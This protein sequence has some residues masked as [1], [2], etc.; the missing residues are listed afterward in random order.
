MSSP[1]VAIIGAGHM[2]GA[3]LKGL[4]QSGWDK[5]KLRASCH[6]AQHAAEIYKTFQINI[7]Q[8]NQTAI[9][10]A[11]IILLCVKPQIMAAVVAEISETLKSR[12]CIVISIAAGITESQLRAWLTPNYPIIRAMPNLP[13][14]IGMSATAL[15]AN[16]FCSAGQRQ[17]AETIFKAIGSIAWVEKED[18]FFAITAL[19]G[20][21]PAYF[22]SLMDA[23]EKAARTYGL[24]EQLIKN[25]TLQTALGSAAMAQESL[26]SSEALCQKV[27]SPGGGTEQALNM[28]N[29]LQFNEIILKA[30]A[31]AEQRYR[32]LAEN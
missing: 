6:S 16:R 12:P 11:E 19:Y 4:I 10:E 22:F 21:G 23:L 14:A 15:Y 8:C 28:L 5:S 32:K 17:I 3:I 25:F 13:A 31:A 20:S 30:V 2:G 26:L 7:T 18:D 1:T 27:A 29:S 24:S 9:A